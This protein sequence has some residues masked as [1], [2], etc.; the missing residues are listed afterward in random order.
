MNLFS[1]TH[2]HLDFDT[3]I[4]DREE[5][6]YR[7][8]VAGLSII[9]NPGID[10]TS[11]QKA[12]SLAHQFSNFI[13]AAVG[14]HPNYGYLWNSSSYQSLLEIAK[15]DVVIAIGEIGLDYYRDHTPRE[16]QYQVFLEQLKL[17]REL[18]LPVLIHNR[19]ASSDLLPILSEWVKNLPLESRLRQFPGVFHSFSD[20]LEIA[21]TAI[22]MNFMIGITGPVTFKN[23]LERK[24]LVSHLP[25]SSLLLETDAPFLTPHPWRG[26]RNEPAYI[27]LIATKVAQ[28]HNINTEEL[29]QITLFN[30]KKLLNI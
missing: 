18:E 6:I 13:Y 23:A 7:A 10:L 8:K 4:N 30:T 2:C 25:L 16:I 14:F 12:V 20:K 3:F 27:P 9:I 28:L 15:D 29:A 1:D 17:A 21:L 26:R 22:E 24:E 5:V 19:D 11:S